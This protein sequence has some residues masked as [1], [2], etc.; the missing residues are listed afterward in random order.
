MDGFNAAL[1]KAVERADRRADRAWGRLAKTLKQLMIVAHAKAENEST[2]AQEQQN[3]ISIIPQLPL[4]TVAHYCGHIFHS[5]RS[6]A[7]KLS[8]EIASHLPEQNVEYGYGSLAAG[9]DILVAEALLAKGAELRVVQ[10]FQVEQYIER[11]VKHFGAQ[12]VSRFESCYDQAAEV[13]LASEDGDV[14]DNLLFS[15]GGKL[16]MGMALLHARSLGHKAM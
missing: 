15:Y 6:R 2:V 13:Q 8:R 4:P 16:A 3:G 12:W 5:D 11:S 1:D 10:P 7:L 14:A 9:S